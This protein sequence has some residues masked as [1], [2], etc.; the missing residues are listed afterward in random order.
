[1]TYTYVSKLITFPS[2][3]LP[4]I[5][6]QIIIWNHTG[7]LIGS[8]GANLSEMNQVEQFL[9]VLNEFQNTVCKMSA[10]L[11]EYQC[12][13]EVSGVGLTSQ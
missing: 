9:Q 12:V 10:I 6:C 7:L 13:N 1:M 2:N 11:S 3:S 5:W 8:F 4:P